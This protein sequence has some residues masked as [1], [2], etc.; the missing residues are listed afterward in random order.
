MGGRKLVVDP[1]DL[2]LA[3]LLHCVTKHLE[4]A[5]SSSRD[6]VGFQNSGMG[7]GFGG[8]LTGGLLVGS[9]TSVGVRAGRSVFCLKAQSG[10]QT[11][12]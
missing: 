9:T 7:C 11:V 4:A 2:M 5:A 10:C 8:E 1:M 12:W 3:V 6:M